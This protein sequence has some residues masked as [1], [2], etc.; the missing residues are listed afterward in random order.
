MPLKR[1]GS[2]WWTEFSINGVRYRRSTGHSH[3]AH[4]EEY[5]ARLRTELHDLQRLGRVKAI[6]YGETVKRYIEDVTLTKPKNRDG[7]VR[8]SPANDIW[9]LGKLVAFWGS[10]A[11]LVQVSKPAAIGQL[12]RSP[13]RSMGASS[14]NRFL[15]LHRA[16]L[17]KAYDWGL[18]AQRPSVHLNAEPRL[19]NRALTA[20]QQQA[21]VRLVP[22]RIHDLVVCILD[23]GICREEAARLT[24]S[25]LNLQRRPRPLLTVRESKNFDHRVIPLPKRTAKLLAARKRRF[26]RASPLVFVYRAERDIFTNAGEHYASPGDVIPIGS[27][28]NMWRQL[29]HALG[30]PHLRLHD[31]RHTYATRL[32]VNG[33]PLPVVAKLLGHR[34]VDSTG[35]YAYL[36]A[37]ELDE[38]VGRLDGG[39]GSRSRRSGTPDLALVRN[40]VAGE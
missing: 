5:E 16:V 13:S 3:R 1:R 21:L 35:R 19:V 28:Q 32:V 26:G 22:E 11:S 31:L 33:V 36:A 17:N 30:L 9:R 29:K 23:T 6:S 4:A 39:R 10:K 20:S 38:A 8:R 25:D 18:V 12:N 7:S 24:W 14:T 2:M 15:G 34:T 37:V 40:L 27:F